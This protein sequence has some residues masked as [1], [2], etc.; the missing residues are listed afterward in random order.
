MRNELTQLIAQLNV[1]GHVQLLGW[2]AQEE[3]TKLME[4]ADIFLAP[5]VMSENGD[6]E[7]TPTVIMEALARGLPVLSTLHSGIPEVVQDGESGFLVPERDTAA[8][9]EKLEYLAG[10]PEI[11]GEMGRTGRAWVEAHHDI[12]KL[13]DRLIQ[14]YERVWAEEFITGV[15]S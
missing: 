8:L 9:A 11:W 3:V 13:N 15:P 5:S 2:R 7:G 4:D 6:Q 12:N 10:H 14:L 1:G